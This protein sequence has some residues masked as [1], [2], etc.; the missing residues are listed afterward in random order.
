MLLYSLLHLTGYDLSLDEVKDF[1][2]WESKTPGH[3][4]CW[5]TPG[6]DVTTGPLGQGFGNGV[7]MAIAE[8]HLRAV[9]NKPDARIV[10]HYTYVLATDGDLMEGISSEAASL[11]G[12]LGLGKL[13]VLYDDNKISI[14]GSTGL[15]FTENVGARFEAFGW[16]TQRV[17]DGNDFDKIDKAITKAKQDNRP[18]L[19]LC[20]THIGFGLPTKQDTAKAHGEPAGEEELEGAKKKLGWPLE[21]WFHIPDDVLEH[22]REALT[23][24]EALETEWQR[25][26]DDYRQRYPDEASEFER[27][28]NRELP[29]GWDSDLPVF[30]PDQ[31]DIATRAASGKTLNVLAPRLGELMGG[32][33]DLTG[34]NK[35][36][37]DGSVA[38]QMDSPEGRNLYF[39]VREH[40]MGA[41]VNGLAAHSGFIPYGASFLVFSD[42]MRPAIRLSSLSQH[43]SI[44]VFTH[45]SIGL[46]EDGP[47]HQPIEH[48]AALRAI[49]DLVVIRPGDA[50]E[51]VEAWKVAVSRKIGPTLIALTRQKIPILDRESLDS[52]EG[53][54]R[55]AYVLADLGDKDTQIILMASGSE[56]H[57]IVDAAQKLAADGV[58]V[59]VVSFPSWELFAEQDEEYKESVLPRSI[60][61]RLAIEAG[62][63]QGWERWVGEKGAVISIECF[64]SSAPHTVLFKEY[65]FTSEHVVKKAHKLLEG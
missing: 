34:S 37:I 55:G 1:R 43:H 36:W 21:P 57:V 48:L 52:A 14:D 35:T 45:D 41:I 16:H 42:Y 27:R 60:P 12:H 64:G 62:I 44:W 5:R 3:P 11:A 30:T 29:E 50:N 23:N 25:L 15:A 46:G 65:G 28:M 39:G 33:A 22:F 26:M 47:T 59:R 53:L 7:G 18:S 13:I 6:I 56:L 38:F 8:K 58:G 2:Q 9:F 4:E 31:G 40:A 17:D 61:A 20:R 10:G 51:V 19:I 49:P 63:S 24:G 32:S 54:E